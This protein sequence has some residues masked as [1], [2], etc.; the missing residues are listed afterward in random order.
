MLHHSPQE[1]QVFCESSAE[2][3]KDKE[4]TE[5]LVAYFKDLAEIC[6]V[7]VAAIDKQVVIPASFKPQGTK[8]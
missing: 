7:V 1:L 8:S 5:H 4:D 6:K 3:I 2:A